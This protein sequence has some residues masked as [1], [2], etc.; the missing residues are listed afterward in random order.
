M[1]SG[2]GTLLKKDFPSPNPIPSSPKTF[3]LLD[4]TMGDV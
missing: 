3:V 2:R 4:R 1:E